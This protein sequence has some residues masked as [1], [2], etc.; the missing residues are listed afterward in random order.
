M[1]GSQVEGKEKE[2]GPPP[3]AAAATAAGWDDDSD[4]RGEEG[5]PHA[6]HLWERR[7]SFRGQDGPGGAAVEGKLR[8][9]YTAKKKENCVIR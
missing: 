6:Q 8:T 3:A 1:S 2:A 4:Q 9:N 7:Q 5:Q